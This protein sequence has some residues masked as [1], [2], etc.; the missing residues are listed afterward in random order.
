VTSLW[1]WSITAGFRFSPDFLNAHA[2]WFLAVPA[3]TIA[4]APAYGVRISLSVF[5]TIVRLLQA[6]AL[7]LG[8]YLV[9]YFYS[10]RYQLPRLM[11]LYVLWDGF[12]LVLAWRLIFAWFFSRDL[13][14]RRVLIVGA[15]EPGL[16]ALRLLRD[17][18]FRNST[19]VAL[20][21]VPG[22]SA[23]TTAGYRAPSAA[24]PSRGLD[25]DPAGA[26]EIGSSVEGLPVVPASTPLL[27]CARQLEVN[28]IVLAHSGAQSDLFPSLV[29][30][31]ELG[32][33][34]ATMPQVYEDLLHR[35]PVQ[36]L[37]S[38]WLFTSFVEAV[39]AKDSSLVAKRAAD[40]AGAS[41]GLLG[42]LILTPFI[43]LAI[44]L[45]SGRPIFFRQVR[46][47]RAG[48]EFVMFKFRTMVP[49]AERETGPKWSTAGDPRI[50]RTGRLLRKLRLDELPNLVNVL[51]GEMSLVGPRPERPEIVRL[52]VREI[53]FYRSRLIVRPG[54]T[55]WAQVNHPYG[56][57]VEDAV[58][59]LEYDLYYLKHRSMLFDLRI[60]LRTA[61]TVLRLGG[62]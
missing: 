40:L 35:V 26:L 28:E 49:D 18:D 46:R 23:E 56:D 5:D 45:D 11:G 12:L 8:A 51:R 10:P 16:T 47:G 15:G 25:R 36:H 38:S 31:Q 7:L 60:L 48:R 4:L 39:R 53:P 21:D 41:I 9:L 42:L 44:W 22:A 30:C 58:Q 20:L 61:G 37:E 13:F 33:D 57:S 19:V 43:A 32:I 55:G 54:L 27:E 2:I 6:A 52:L 14:A 50:T 3:W 1:L 59:K 62:R 24:A 29:E 34:I 17:F